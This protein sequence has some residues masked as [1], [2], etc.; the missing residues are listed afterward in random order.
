MD[1]NKEKLVSDL[2]NKV[3]NLNDK[4]KLEDLLK[5][6]NAEFTIDKITYRV[7]KPNGAKNKELRRAR[8]ER[9]FQLLKDPS[10]K[11]KEV[12]IKELKEKGYDIIAEELKIK[13]IGYTIE[14][15][16]A[17]VAEV[18]TEST[19]VLKDYEK[20]VDELKQKQAEISVRIDELM[21][22]SIEQELLEFSN[23]YLIYSVLEKEVE[24]R[25][26]EVKEED[27][28]SKKWI[29]A[30]KTYEEYLDSDNEP[31]RLE[32][33]YYMSMITFKPKV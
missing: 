22:F 23:N 18:P 30:F 7:S 19:Q 28:Y 14:D 29:N 21:E 24:D 1:K 12:L 31:L 4:E 25:S 32:S 6:N 11:L 17:K 16:E 5:N 2:V 20:D 27:N 26:V 8:N 15:I 3:K 9:F 33:L 10:F 13:E